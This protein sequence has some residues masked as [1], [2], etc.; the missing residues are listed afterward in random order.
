MT[1]TLPV[2]DSFSNK[3]KKSSTNLFE[4]IDTYILG[5]VFSMFNDLRKVAVAQLLYDIVVLGTLHNIVEANS[6]VRD[7]R[8]ENLYLV[9]K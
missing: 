9:L 7:H 1:E 6:K 8:P 5:E 3:G 2:D 4:D